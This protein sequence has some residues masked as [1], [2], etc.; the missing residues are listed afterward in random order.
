MYV[1]ITNIHV[2]HVPI[3]YLSS[4]LPPCQTFFGR[5][6]VQGSNDKCSKPHG[7][8]IYPEH[9]IQQATSIS[10]VNLNFRNVC[11]SPVSF[12]HSS[13]NSA[14]A[15]MYYVLTRHCG[16]MPLHPTRKLTD[17]QPKGRSGCSGTSLDTGTVLVAIGSGMSA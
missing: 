14:S 12:L 10:G 2:P 13:L 4:H 8:H 15:G 7:S 1:F 17:D 6:A 3:V 5:I 11:L 9:H 16:S